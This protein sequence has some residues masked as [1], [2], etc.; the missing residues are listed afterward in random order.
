MEE[1]GTIVVSDNAADGPA[2]LVEMHAAYYGRA[3]GFG[4]FFRDKVAADLQEFR[5]RAAA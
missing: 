5:A 2:R 3:W 4:T 1:G